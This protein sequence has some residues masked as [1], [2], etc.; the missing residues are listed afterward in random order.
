M[1][2]GCTDLAFPICGIE[3][4]E[5]DESIIN[6]NECFKCVRTTDSIVGYDYGCSEGKPLCDADTGKGGVECLRVGKKWLFNIGGIV[7]RSPN[8]PVETHTP[9]SYYLGPPGPQGETGPQ[10]LAGATGPQGETGE[11]GPQGLAGE[12]GPQGETGEGGPQGLAGETG[13]QGETGESGPQG[14]AGA[15]GPQGETGESGTQGETGAQGESG[16]QG[17]Q[18]PTGESGPQGIQG[19]TGESP[20]LDAL[21][22]LVCD[23]FRANGADMGLLRACQKHLFI[24]SETFDGALGGVSGADAHC[25]RLAEAASLPGT[26]MVW[27]STSVV[28]EPAVRFS[29]SILPYVRVDGTVL[30]NNW[31]DLVDGEITE[32]IAYDEYG[33]TLTN[34]RGVF[35]TTTEHGTFDD[36]TSSTCDDYTIASVDPSPTGAASPLAAFPSGS[37]GTNPLRE[38]GLIRCSE[39]Y[40]RLI[41]VQQ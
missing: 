18:G 10:G 32:Y 19:P 27:L 35:A 21:Y 12:T 31:D 5:Q 40:T 15:T 8:S 28:D 38:N 17:I 20:D 3:D 11:S 9:T 41:C 4:A 33:N 39:G 25:Q 2:Q 26:Y 30:A 23:Q 6:G 29:Q 34:P 24:T 14:L 37:T 13:P 1:D 16:P 7:A 36:R 22:S